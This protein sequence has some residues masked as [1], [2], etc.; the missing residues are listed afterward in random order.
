[1]DRASVSVFAIWGSMVDVYPAVVSQGKDVA[2][3]AQMELVI[4]HCLSSSH[5]DFCQKLLLSFFKI[6]S[7][8]QDL[9]M[10][11]ETRNAEARAPD[12]LR[13]VDWI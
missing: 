2:V 8:Q 5:M 6:Y 4:N 7:E 1:M 10:L 3:A 9:A 11:G 13:N 12:I